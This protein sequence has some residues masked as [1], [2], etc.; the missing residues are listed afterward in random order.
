MTSGE[1]LS[2]NLDMTH[3]SYF[4]ASNDVEM[5]FQVNLCVHLSRMIVGRQ[6]TSQNFIFLIQRLFFV[7]KR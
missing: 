5:D 7:G 1:F 4:Q 3:L 2:E 6:K